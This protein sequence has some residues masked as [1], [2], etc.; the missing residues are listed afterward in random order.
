[1][2][3]ALIILAVIFVGCKQPSQKSENIGDGYYVK[4]IDSCQYI[5]YENSI[6]VANNYSYSITH[7][8]NCNNPIHKT[9]N[10]GE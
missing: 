3:K 5:I 7:K 6:S 4:T 8:G 10:N 2:K 1:M 9:Y